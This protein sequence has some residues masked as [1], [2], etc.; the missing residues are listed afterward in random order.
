MDSGES[1]EMKIEI[2]I[3]DWALEHHLYLL[4]GTELVAIKYLEENE[5]KI[6]T[7]RCRQCGGCCLVHPKNN[8]HFPL[9]EDGSCSKLIEDGHKRLCSLGM[10]KPL[11]CI[12]SRNCEKEYEQYGCT[13]TYNGER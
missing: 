1:G 11:V 13:V 2:E 6:K 10:D 8:P 4:S 7:S 5:W 3:P 9:N 12:V